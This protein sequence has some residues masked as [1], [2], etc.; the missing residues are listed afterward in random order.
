MM[1]FSRK[2]MAYSLHTCAKM[3]NFLPKS[4]DYSLHTCAK[5]KKVVTK[6]HGQWPSHIRNNDAFFTKMLA[7]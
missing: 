2:N 7:L 6:K 3:M 4:M 1:D 5:M